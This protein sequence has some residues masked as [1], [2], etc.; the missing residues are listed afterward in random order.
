MAAMAECWRDL[1]W[2]DR[3]NLTKLKAQCIGV[4]AA[5]KGLKK[6]Q[7]LQQAKGWNSSKY[8]EILEAVVTGTEE[9]REEV[10][11]RAARVN[12]GTGRHLRFTK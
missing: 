12:R 10:R 8:V 3:Y 11:P 4:V 9:V 1:E 6:R 7:E 5:D 2:A